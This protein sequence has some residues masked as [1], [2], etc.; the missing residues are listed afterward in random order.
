MQITAVSGTTIAHVDEDE[1]HRMVECGKSFLHLKQLLSAKVGHSRFRQRLLSDTM[2]ELHDDMPL[3]P[4]SSVQL[5]LVDFCPLDEIRGYELLRSCQWNNVVEVDKL[6]RTPHDPNWR[7]GNTGIAPIYVAAQYGHLRLARLLLEAGADKDAAR[8][9]G[10]TPLLI[11]AGNGHL[12]VVRL[13]LGAG[14]DKDTAKSTGA[15]ALIIAAENG[16]LEVVRLLLEAGADTLAAKVTGETALHVAAR[17]GHLDVV[18]L[19]LKARAD[20]DAASSHWAR[21][22]FVAAGMAIWKSCGC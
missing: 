21:S 22:L 2:G 14:A 16:H 9:N 17:N 8:S 13:L 3:I 5:V 18:R 12:E 19:L 11:A 7:G 1:L 15:T 6:L 10:T 4:V 20:N